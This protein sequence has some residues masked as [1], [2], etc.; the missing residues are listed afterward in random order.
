MFLCY[1]DESGDTG[2]HHN[3][4]PY[5]I[6]TAFVVHELR[7]LPTLDA[8][9]DHRRALRARYG[10]KVR[11]ELH[12]QELLFHPGD[13]ARIPKSLRLHMLGDVLTFAGAL[14]D[15]AIM[16]VVVNKAAKPADYDVFAQAWTTLLQRF[17]MGVSRRSFP[18]PTNADERGLLVTD[19]TDELKLRRLARRLRR[20]NPVPSK[21][22]TPPRAMPMTLLV[23]DPVHRD[24]KHAYFIQLA[25]IVSYFL[26]QRLAPNGYVKKKGARNWFLRVEPVLYK[27]AASSD[28][29]GI[30]IL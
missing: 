29:L 9:L 30:V 1:V 11:E 25:D 18:G 13:A 14:T 5:F 23:E 12:A 4:S 24:S 19:Q 15:V 27:V 20:Y 22:G 6:L 10:F 3:A 16:N 17:H 8:V 2:M 28:P 7:W 26:K 21:F